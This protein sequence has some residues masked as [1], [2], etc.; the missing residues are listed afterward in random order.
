VQPMTQARAAIHRET[1]VA[2]PAL[3]VW[4]VRRI[5]PLVY[6]LSAKTVALV[7]GVKQIC[8]W[9]CAKLNS[10]AGV[11]CGIVPA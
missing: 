4:N 11:R 8:S 7:S 10:C 9:E 5:S 3:K 1:A 2:N 6:A